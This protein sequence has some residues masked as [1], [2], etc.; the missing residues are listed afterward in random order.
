M[1]IRR[2]EKGSVFR[3]PLYSGVEA[4]E[5]DEELEQLVS[6]LKA[7]DGGPTEIA[8]SEC[9]QAIA[10]LE[11]KAIHAASPPPVRITSDESLKGVVVGVIYRGPKVAARWKGTMSAIQISEAR[12]LGESRRGL[13]EQLV[14]E[15]YEKGALS[16]DGIEAYAD[17]IDRVFKEGVAFVD[18]V[19]G[20]EQSDIP[21]DTPPTAR[22]D[23]F[24]EEVAEWLQELAYDEQM[25]LMRAIID[26]QS[27]RRRQIFPA[28]GD[29]LD[30]ARPAAP[31][32]AVE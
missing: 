8:A 29:G 7:P 1:G 23:A 32:G 27:V 14:P 24:R 9:S 5:V 11:E 2:P 26:T 22:H 19:D 20:I 15:L 17:L 10:Y 4:F 13:G 12:A 30:G 18:G 6:R 25:R 31:A 28:A 21:T 3:L 16:A